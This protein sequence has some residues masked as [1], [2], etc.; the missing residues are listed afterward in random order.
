MNIFFLK[1]RWNFPA[2]EILLLALPALIAG[3]TVIVKPSE[4]SP[5]TGAMVVNAVASALPLSVFQVAQG[6]GGIGARLVASPSI[7]MVAMTGSS[8]VGKKIMAGC[9]NELKRLVLELGGKD[10]MVSSSS[11]FSS[12]FFFIIFFFILFRLLLS[13]SLF[14]YHHL[15]SYSFFFPLNTR[16]C[17]LM[18]TWIELHTMLFSSV[19]STLVKYAAV[20]NAFM[21]MLSLKMNLKGEF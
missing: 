21:S 2:D 11:S 12:S 8:A 19:Y 3:N 14:H 10:A 17:L 18:L 4:V 13:L 7:D 16:L 20:W 15:H 5:S 6:D 1:N 9:A